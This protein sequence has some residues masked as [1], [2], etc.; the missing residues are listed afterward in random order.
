MDA[1]PSVDSPP[2]VSDQ[3]TLLSAVEK[4]LDE[5]TPRYTAWGETKTAIEWAKDPRCTVDQGLICARLA[6]GMGIESAITMPKKWSGKISRF[7]GVSYLKDRNTWTAQIRRGKKVI[8]IGT[9]STELEAAV[10]YDRYARKIKPWAR[11]NFRE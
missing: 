8:Y 6:V 2:L 5:I 3:A 9:F 1:Y 4:K 10:A 7:R 11:L